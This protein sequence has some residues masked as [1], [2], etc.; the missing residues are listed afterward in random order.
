MTIPSV[1]NVCYY[2]VLLELLSN[3]AINIPNSAMNQ[4]E[5]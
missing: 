3:F 4:L 5:Y 1:S 2:L